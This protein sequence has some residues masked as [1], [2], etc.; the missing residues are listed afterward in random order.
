MKIRSMSLAIFS[1]GAAI[2]AGAAE[3][4]AVNGSVQ[5]VSGR[6]S[7]VVK[8]EDGKLKVGGREL[9]LEDTLYLNM[10]TQPQI[11]RKRLQLP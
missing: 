10:Q 11:Y 9:K 5:A 2:M 4:E 7:G 1:I 6:F 3:P 8:V